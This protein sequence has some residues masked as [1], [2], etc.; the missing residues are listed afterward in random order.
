MKRILLFI[1]LIINIYSCQRANVDVVECIKMGTPM[2]R[3]ADSKSEAYYWCDD[4]KVPLTIND[5]KLFVVMETS[6][7][8]TSPI[9]D[10]ASNV[11][12]LEK[13]T[14]LGIKSSKDFRNTY[15]LTSFT[16]EKVLRKDANLKDATYIAPYYKTSDGFEMGITNVLS[17]KVTSDSDIDKLSTIAKEYNLD[18]L[19]NNLYDTS[20]YYL[21]CTKESNG[22]A[23]EIANSIYESGEFK[24]ATP[25]FIIE[26]KP[27]INPN[28][29]LFRSQ[30]NLNNTAYPEIDIDYVNLFT[31]FTFPNIN[32]IIVAVVDNG[33]YTEHI[34]LPIIDM[35]YDAHTGSEPSVIYG[36]HGT[37]VAGVIGATTNN[38]KGVSGIASGVKIM[39]ISICYSGDVN[40]HNPTAS[41]STNF[42]NAIRY[43]ASHGARVINNSW[44]FSTSSPIAEI[45]SAI[46]YAHEQNC[47]VVFSSGNDDGNI[48]QPAAGAPFATLVVGA[49]DENGQKASFSNY[50]SSLD[51]VAPGVNIWS[52]DW[53]DNY[54]YYSGT[55]FAAPHV[56][57]IAALIWAKNPNLPAWKVRDIIEQTAHKIGSND[58][59]NVYTHTNGS[60]NQYYGYG[61]VNA[62]D[63]VSAVVGN[64]STTPLIYVPLTEIS[65]SDVISMELDDADAWDSIYLARGPGHITIEIGNYDSTATYE[66]TSTLSPYTGYGS[67]FTIEY[68]SPST[69]ILHDVT[70]R[71]IKNGVSIITG[72]SI[73]VIPFNY[74]Y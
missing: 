52:T 17:V 38:S 5:D 51:L 7:Y 49:I 3:S 14:P 42:A 34:D 20:I 45:N 54:D 35:G 71:C 60:W 11:K 58:Y 66:W 36:D 10:F 18:I 69:P 70:C 57:A 48:S 16:I 27:A 2:T 32:N 23:L 43:A 19:G 68:Q 64:N 47:V 73:V 72:A 74:S 29:P 22:N 46:E 13:Y 33:V 55:S 50:G 25:E 65:V 59:S 4:V 21:S 56:S 61:L 44:S 40:A 24:Y 37:A 15:N 67:S 26:S 63:A 8:N 41:T 62:Y 9:S 39:P 28:D 6:V 53:S 31:D 30:W 12:K 1:C